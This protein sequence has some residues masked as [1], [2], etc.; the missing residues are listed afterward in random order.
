MQ[1]QIKQLL[2]LSEQRR[3]EMAE[4]IQILNQKPRKYDPA[5]ESEDE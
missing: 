4:L 1:N 3:K 5:S 2:A